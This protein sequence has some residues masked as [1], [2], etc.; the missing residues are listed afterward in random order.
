MLMRD[1]VVTKNLLSG[2]CGLHASQQIG[3]FQASAGGLEIIARALPATDVLA[4][5]G[6]AKGFAGIWAKLQNP[7]G[8]ATCVKQFAR[9]AVFQ[10]RVAR[11]LLVE[12]AQGGCELLQVAWLKGSSHA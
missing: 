5:G 10:V 6:E 9:L 11:V 8:Q 1:R 4:A 12:A 3:R 2:R 7:V